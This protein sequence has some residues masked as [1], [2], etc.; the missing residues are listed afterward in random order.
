MPAILR[1][2]RVAPAIAVIVLPM[3]NTFCEVLGTGNRSRSLLGA[4]ALEWRRDE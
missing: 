3:V 1:L 4:S 2:T